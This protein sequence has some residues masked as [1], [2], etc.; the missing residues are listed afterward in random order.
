MRREEK[1]ELIYDYCRVAEI[2]DVQCSDNEKSLGIIKRCA[3]LDVCIHQ[4]TKIFPARES[5]VALNIMRCFVD[6]TDVNG[7]TRHKGNNAAIRYSRFEK[8]F[9]LQ[10]FGDFKIDDDNDILYKHCNLKKFRFYI[11]REFINH[12]FEVDIACTFSRDANYIDAYLAHTSNMIDMCCRGQIKIE[13]IDWIYY[14]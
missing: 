7:V 2:K 5:Q 6:N 3:A 4:G 12:T 11:T 1:A 14:D 10:D 8:Y 13:D 9:Y